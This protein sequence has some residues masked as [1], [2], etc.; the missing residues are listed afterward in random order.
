MQKGAQWRMNSLLEWEKEQFRKNIH[1]TMIKVIRWLA[2]S[3]EDNLFEIEEKK[4]ESLKNNVKLPPTIYWKN[5]SHYLAVYTESE[6]KDIYSTIYS[7]RLYKCLYDTEIEFNRD[8]ESFLEKCICLFRLEENMRQ[9]IT[10]KYIGENA[11][12][13]E[14]F[15]NEVLELT[16]VLI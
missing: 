4:A 2:L 14:D 6:E 7:Y 9:G 5:V 11:E 8:I 13:W 16:G 3:G 1:K 10:Y 12:W 15:R